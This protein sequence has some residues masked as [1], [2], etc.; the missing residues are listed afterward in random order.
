MLSDNAFYLSECDATGAEGAS[1]EA[2]IL[3]PL[4]KMTFGTASH[5]FC[6]YFQM[7]K[8]LVVKCCDEYALMIKDL[9][10]FECLQVPDE[11]NLKGICRLHC[12]VN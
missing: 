3:L 4:K 12:A 10:S 5:A 7:S 6:N 2:K 9:Y 1:L 8:P 11:N